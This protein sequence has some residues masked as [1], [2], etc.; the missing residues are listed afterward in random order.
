MV[1]ATHLKATANVALGLV[2]CLLAFTGGARADEMLKLDEKLSSVPVAPAASPAV[3][4]LPARAQWPI[5]SPRQYRIGEEDL[6]EIKVFG[7]EQLTSTV[8][9]NPR[10]QITLPLIGAVHV[11]GLTAQ[12]A[13]ALIAA[14][15][16]ESY[17]Q[18][19]QVS[20]F[21]KEFT[22]QRVTVEGAVVRPGVYPLKGH[23]SLL[24]S[25]A[26]AGGPARM[27]ETSQVLLF[28][29]DGT[30]KRVATMYDVDR[31]RTGELPDPEVFNDD[32][33]VVNRTA[34]RVVLRDSLFGD[35]L[36]VLNPFR[37][38]PAP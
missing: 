2:L 35:M 28:R 3:N 33:I 10:G 12:A 38:I 15:L 30:G 27:S 21:I 24:T 9:V 32:L 18:N 6:L 11:A 22:T 37:Y 1:H 7:V 31:I 5:D 14:K 34:S 23:S 17:L 8:R 36:D 26:L 16:G 19:P 13:E 4:S 20:L 29:P 25:L